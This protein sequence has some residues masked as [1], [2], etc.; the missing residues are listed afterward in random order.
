M[1]FLITIS[2]MRLGS[3]PFIVLLLQAQALEV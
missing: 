1:P 3:I 2:E